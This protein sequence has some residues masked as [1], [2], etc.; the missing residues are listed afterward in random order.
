M[1]AA[2]HPA[3]PSPGECLPGHASQLCRPPPIVNRIEPTKKVMASAESPTRLAYP[4]N[5]PMKKQVEP[6]AKQSAIQR[7]RVMLGQSSDK[8]G[9]EHHPNQT[10]REPGRARLPPR[11]FLDAWKRLL[12][13]WADRGA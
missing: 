5:G 11:A 9:S 7:R 1:T 2:H 6:S 4:G 13:R 10:R 12:T 8:R 3:R